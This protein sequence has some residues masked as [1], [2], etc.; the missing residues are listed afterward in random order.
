M[1]YNKTKPY[2]KKV[3][4]YNNFNS[5]KEITIP[6][7]YIL[8]QGWHKVVKRLQQNKIAFTRFKKDT[9]IFV[10]TQHIKDFETRNTAYEG[11]YLHYNTSVN[12]E[13][14]SILL[15]KGDLYI[16]TQQ[17]GIRYIIETLE[18]EATDSFFNW[19]FFDS[20]LQQKEGFSAYVFEDVAAK[21]LK[22]NPLVKKALNDK[23]NKDTLFA[24]NPYAQLYFVYKKTPHYEEAHMKLPIYKKY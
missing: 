6:K 4:Y 2:T 15:K 18:A 24:K 17:Q 8:Q 19:N 10:E 14:K 21:F 13:T 1:F 16:P 11:H 7:A 20:V 9:I 22:E 5:T 3:T 23:I 12:K